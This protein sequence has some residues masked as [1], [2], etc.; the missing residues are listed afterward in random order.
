MNKLL[1]IL[2]VLALFSC[3]NSE[4][5]APTEVAKSEVKKASKKKSKTVTFSVKI[6]QPYCGG[7]EPSEEMENMR[8]KGE[9]AKQ[10]VFYIYQEEGIPIKMMTNMDGAATADMANGSFCIKE[11]YKSDP[12]MLKGIIDSDWEFDQECFTQWKE[13]CILEF[14]VSD[15]STNL[16]NFTYRP[17]CGWEGPV[18]CITN[19][20][21]PPP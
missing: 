20:G 6:I 3:K 11:G 18:P 7:V 19:T 13:Q 8:M 2:Y 10:F 9:P 14:V 5:K 12:E 17:R 16:V 21:F 15:T 4:Q 1:Y